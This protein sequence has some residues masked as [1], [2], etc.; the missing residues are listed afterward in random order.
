MLKTIILARTV[1]HLQI[2][3]ILKIT[4]TE[5]IINEEFIFITTSHNG[6]V[7]SARRLIK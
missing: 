7:A 4:L 6:P 3:S 1:A 5:R 2:P